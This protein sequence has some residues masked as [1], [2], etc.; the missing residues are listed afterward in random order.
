MLLLVHR[1]DGITR[2]LQCQQHKYLFQT[3]L[4]ALEEGKK[5]S[6]ELFR[7][8]PQLSDFTII[9]SVIITRK[10][11]TVLRVNTWNQVPVYL[12]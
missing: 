7:K 2:T 8:L 12:F 9:T 1:T 3:N 10:H 4:S 11:I 5:E 6:F